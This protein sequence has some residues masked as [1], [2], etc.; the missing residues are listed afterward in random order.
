MFALI[1]AASLLV[2]LQTTTTSCRKEDGDCQRYLPDEV[3][4]LQTSSKLETSSS[5]PG[6]ATVVA[7]KG[8]LA[9]KETPKPE[10]RKLASVAKH[11][12]ILGDNKTT[13]KS[14]NTSSSSWLK[15]EKPKDQ[16]WNLVKLDLWQH[17]HAQCLDGSAGSFYIQKSKTDDASQKWVIHHQGGSW[18]TLDVPDRDKGWEQVEHCLQRTTRALGS[19]VPLSSTLDSKQTESV[20]NG[21]LSADKR[22]NPMMHDWNHVYL[23]YC[24]GGSFSGRNVTPTIY[25]DCTDEKDDK[26]CST[27]ELHFKGHYVLEAAMKTLL[28]KHNMTNAEEVVLSGC[29]SGGLAVLL[30][31]D[32]WRAALPE[33][34]FTAALV[35]SGFFLDWSLNSPE[36]EPRDFGNQL[37]SVFRLH[38]SSGSMHAE[39]LHR[40]SSLGDPASACFFPEH[41]TSYL[42]VPT[43]TA[44][45]MVD[46]FQLKAV[47][48]IDA[49]DNDKDKKEEIKE[50]VNA[51]RNYMAL[52]MNMSLLSH[53]QNGA[54]VSSCQYH[55]GQFN[56]LNIDG[57]HISDA[58]G[59]W[60][61]SR[62]ASFKNETTSSMEPENSLRLWQDREWKCHD[63]CD[64]GKLV[65][66]KEIR[67]KDDKEGKPDTLEETT[68]K[69]KAGK[70]V[71]AG[72]T[73]TDKAAV[74]SEGVSSLSEDADKKEEVDTKTAPKSITETDE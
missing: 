36:S 50:Q 64:P 74:E 3:T 62:H 24:D 42:Q 31:A 5:K 69:G 39:C 35:D 71:E 19:S 14:S 21:E 13:N 44:Q 30:H 73:A 18:C 27:R 38:N 60:Y 23:N 4:L 8:K 66:E 15:V 1:L 72:A 52:A 34:T 48:G 59:K 9:A 16:P 54:F 46:S 67:E 43:F 61:E 45:S 63:C 33:K 51:Y 7:S 65:T 58:F 28:E 26:S 22:V 29:G 6:K 20:K 68:T 57:R 12:T 2:E 17:P 25:H 32:Q 47:L 49:A 55:C 56:S 70:E 41:A 11:L 37:R 40:Q 53:P 10:Q